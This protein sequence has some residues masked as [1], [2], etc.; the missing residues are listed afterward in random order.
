ME[1]IRIALPVFE[2]SSSPQ[3]QLVS[4]EPDE[5][6]SRSIAALGSSRGSCWIDGSDLVFLS[7]GLALA[8]A[9]AAPFCDAWRHTGLPT[10]LCALSPELPGSAVAFA[11][12]WLD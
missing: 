3:G 11:L 7:D 10:Y 12:D 8:F 1:A 4:F 6:L 5:L 9:G 2:L